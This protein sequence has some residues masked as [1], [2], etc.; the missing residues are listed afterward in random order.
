MDHH[1][2]NISAGKIGSSMREWI[3]ST[4]FVHEI[5]SNPFVISLFMLL[6]IWLLDMLYSKTFEC[7]NN[8]EVAQHVLTSYIVLTSGILL[9]NLT[10]NYK[11]NTTASV[12]TNIFIGPEQISNDNIFIGPEQISNHNIL[13]DNILSEYL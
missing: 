8:R 7:V 12:D 3:N 4:P 11:K 10:I 5:I 2:S 13:S 1:N 6:I 9:N